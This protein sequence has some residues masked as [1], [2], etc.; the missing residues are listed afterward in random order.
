MMDVKKI[1][2]SIMKEM[3]EQQEMDMAIVRK[4]QDKVLRSEGAVLALSYFMQKVDEAEK[5]EKKNDNP[6]KT[7]NKAKRS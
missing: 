7:G 5:A 6:K 2:K 3:Q 4:H 1:V